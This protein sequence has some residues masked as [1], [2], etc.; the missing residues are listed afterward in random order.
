MTDPLSER[1][2]AMRRSDVRDLL[3]HAG[4]PGMVSLA[5]GLPA[6]ECFDVDG[7]RAATAAALADRPAEALQY[8]ET[9]GDPG[10]R[11]AIAARSR[12]RGIEVDDA[13]PVIT[14]GSQQG[15]D[16][17]ARALL[18]D[19]D[20]VVVERPAYLAALQAFGLAR[21]RWCPLD[22]DADGARVDALDAACAGLRPKLVYV[23]PDFA[24]P[25]GAT[26][27]LA[28]REALV[29]WAA[30]R[31]VTVLEDDPYGALRTRGTPLPPLAALA[32]EVPGASRWVAH[33]STLSKTVAPGLRVGWLLLPPWLRDAVVRL[34]QATDLHTASL[35]QAV[36]RHYLASGRLDARLGIVRAEYGRRRDALAGALAEAFGDR[37]AM[38]VPD[39]GM[40][41]WARFVDGTDT[42][43]LLE[44]AIARGVTFV[45]G[46]AFF[47]GAAEPGWLRL[48]FS[49]CPPERLREGVRRLADAHAALRR[50]AGV[51]GVAGGG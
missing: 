51:A 48:N 30:R 42:R 20:A 37:L 22:G 15:L 32:R 44:P 8:G 45:P 39:G 12:D 33:A 47:V 3:R 24:N 7:L 49:A 1:V 13:A 38:H 21:P 4:L 41:V 14:A 28:R 6:A 43:A 23:V 2:R 46:D 10:L 31:E 26:M 25:T 35:S 16:L 40:F 18:D 5:G 27:S 19:G 29:R 50:G 17:V 9:E 36:A 11:A 34:K